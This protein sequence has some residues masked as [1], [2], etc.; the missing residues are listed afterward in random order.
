[1]KPS[2]GCYNTVLSKNLARTTNNAI[3]KTIPKAS[4][5][6]KHHL[7]YSTVVLKQKHFGRLDIEL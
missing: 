6:T 3:S 1:M 2:D 5:T 4:Y 7:L